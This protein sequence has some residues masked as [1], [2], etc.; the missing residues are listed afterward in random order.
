M[1]NAPRSLLPLAFLAAAL[2]ASAAPAQNS[3]KTPDAPLDFDPARPERIDGWWTNGKELMCL[4][5]NGAYR[6]WVSQD[7]FKRPVEVGAWRRTNYVFFDLEPYR[8]KPGTRFRVNLQKDGGVTE[9]VRDGMGDFRSV[10]SPPRVMADEMLGAWVSP[11]EQLLVL[12]SGRYEWR[13]TGPAQGITEHSGNWNS[14]GDVLTLAPDTTAVELTSLRCVRGADGQWTLESR[15]GRMTRPPLGPP[16]GG[17]ADDGV[18]PAAPKAPAP[19][20]GAPPASGTP[21]PAKPSA[22]G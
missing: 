13:R 7:R 3:K 6:L 8:A 5:G 2:A 17:G 22:D 18:P 1:M 21:A 15:G 19:P 10:P 11:Q 14:E 16:P 9:L 12:D 20:P 4:D